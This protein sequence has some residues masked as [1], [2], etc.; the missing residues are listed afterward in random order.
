MLGEARNPHGH[1]EDENSDDADFAELIS[2]ERTQNL[3]VGQFHET[4]SEANNVA[5]VKH[6]TVPSISLAQLFRGGDVEQEVAERPLKGVQC[7]VEEIKCEDCQADCGV[8]PL[9]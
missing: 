1:N 3:P 8:F 9:E 4:K 7:E 5:D 2:S 6:T